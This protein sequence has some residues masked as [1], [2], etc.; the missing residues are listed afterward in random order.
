MNRIHRGNIP[1]DSPPAHLSGISG[2]DGGP[3][4][5]ICWL[6]YVP[7]KIFRHSG[8]RLYP[9]TKSVGLQT[10]SMPCP[11][12]YMTP[13]KTSAG[14]KRDGAYWGDAASASLIADTTTTG[15]PAGNCRSRSYQRD[16]QWTK[17]AFWASRYDLRESEP[18]A[19]RGGHM[20]PIKGVHCRPVGPWPSGFELGLRALSF[21]AYDIYA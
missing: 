19:G 6:F 15:C 9:L 2:G 8:P 17:T 5:A 14:A 7:Y 18:A 1:L 16:A 13:T 12:T 11:P 4:W 21:S 20:E 10:P 3:Y